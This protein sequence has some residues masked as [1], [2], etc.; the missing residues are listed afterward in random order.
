MAHSFVVQH[1]GGGAHLWYIPTIL[2][3]YTLTPLFQRFIEAYGKNIIVFTLGL[4]ITCA[5]IFVG[6][7]RYYNAAWISCYFLGYIFGYFEKQKLTRQKT[8]FKTVI[9]ALAIGMLCIR[10][11]MGNLVDIPATGLV[12]AMRSY[13]NNYAHV[14]LGTAIV[15]N[16]KDILDVF[17]N[18]RS[19]PPI[20]G[21][22]DRLSY[23]AYL[24]HHFLIFGPLSLMKLTNILALNIILV[25]CI[26]IVWAIVIQKITTIIMSYCNGR[27]IMTATNFQ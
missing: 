1:C 16:C 8:L 4:F 22:T 26:A 21:I 5:I 19:V 23:G 20:L 27:K 6:Y 14:M 25:F 18:N 9:T 7:L 12:N 3:C 10:L 13:W 24:T 11:I 2:L 17:W 15:V